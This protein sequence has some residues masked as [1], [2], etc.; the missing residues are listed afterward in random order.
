[1][2]L[3]T[4]HHPTICAINNKSRK[5]TSTTLEK[6]TYPLSPSYMQKNVAFCHFYQ[7]VV[8]LYLLWITMNFIFGYSQYL[9]NK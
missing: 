4:N 5:E 8:V 6:Y 2:Y 3:S 7:V 1:M 9:S